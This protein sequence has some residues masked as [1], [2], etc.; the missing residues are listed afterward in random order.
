MFQ[1]HARLA[2]NKHLLSQTLTLHLS[3]QLSLNVRTADNSKGY[4]LIYLREVLFCYMSFFYIGSS[5]T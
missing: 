2:N 1:S 5:C 3:T 4:A